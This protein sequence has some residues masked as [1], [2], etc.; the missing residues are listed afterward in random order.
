MYNI[1][2]VDVVRVNKL[3]RLQV[4]VFS[5][6]VGTM[7]IRH[8]LK[9]ISGLPRL[10]YRYGAPVSHIGWLPATHQHFPITAAHV[11]LYM[12]YP[13]TQQAI[14]SSPWQAI[15]ISLWH[16]VDL[17]SYCLPHATCKLIL[18]N[19]NFSWKFTI[20]KKLIM[21]PS[22]HTA[23]RVTPFPRTASRVTPSHPWY[24]LIDLSQWTVYYWFT[25]P[26]RAKQ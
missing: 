18:F 24:L 21:V 2:I 22:P 7:S 13:L 16:A 17:L 23:G 10:Q 9:P 25:S 26:L 6:A 3:E 4:A 19:L 20:R 8:Y 5:V 11:S 15:S 1:C 14:S 12:W